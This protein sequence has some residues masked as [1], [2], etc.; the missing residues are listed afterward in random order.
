MDDGSEKMGCAFSV[1]LTEM[2]QN[3][4]QYLYQQLYQLLP[5]VAVL[6][7]LVLVSSISS[8]ALATRRRL[9]DYAMFYLC[10]MQWKQCAAVNFC[11][12][13]LSGAGA[14]LLT[15][16]GMLVI[17]YTALSEKFLIFWNGYL[18][19]VLAG[20]LLLYLLFSMLMPMMML[21]AV[22]PNSILKS[23]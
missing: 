17:R 19:A 14:I 6:L 2:D 16:L 13:L 12:A 15:G 22:T 9:R 23:N 5:I 8:S 18:A 20:M 10:G 3:S 7:V 21:H 11:Q 1:D 4:K